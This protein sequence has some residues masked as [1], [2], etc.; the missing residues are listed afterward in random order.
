MWSMIPMIVLFVTRNLQSR[1]ILPQSRRSRRRPYLERLEDRTVP[2]SITVLASHLRS[3]GGLHEQVRVVETGTVTYGN[4]ITFDAA[5]GA[6][7]LTPYA[8][9]TYGSFTVATDGTISGT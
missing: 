3:A 8:G 6:Y 4:D 9:G 7:H 5:P 1:S 2:S